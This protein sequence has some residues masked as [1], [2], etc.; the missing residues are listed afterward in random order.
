ML[1][2]SEVFSFLDIYIYFLDFPCNRHEM[3]SL[4]Q[5][6]TNE[7]YNKHEVLLTDLITCRSLYSDRRI[8][9]PRSIYSY[10]RE[11]WLKRVDEATK[12]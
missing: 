2:C 5:S 11:I 8:G 7:E 12:D 9:C 3:D 1:L 6:G 4:K 10:W